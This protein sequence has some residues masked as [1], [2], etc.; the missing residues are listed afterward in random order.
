MIKKIQVTRTLR[1]KNGSLSFTVESEIGSV[2]SK[3]EYKEGDFLKEFE[4]IEAKIYHW[5]QTVE[6]QERFEGLK[7]Q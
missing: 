7:E 4:D 1:A 6:M 5:L 2:I 3:G